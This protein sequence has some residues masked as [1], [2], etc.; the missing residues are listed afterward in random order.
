MTGSRRQRAN[1]NLSKID[2]EAQDGDVIVVP[3]K[4]LSLGEQTKK[5]KVAA[6][7]FSSGA[8]EK[9][10]DNAVLLLDEIKSNPEAK[11][12]KILK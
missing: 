9:L 1:I 8:E 7:S 3:G 11:G 12:I 2:S 6:I 5:Y 4:V 10:K